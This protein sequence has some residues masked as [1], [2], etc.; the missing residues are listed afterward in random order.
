MQADRVLDV[1][2]SECWVKEFLFLARAG[3]DL[4]PSH[5]AVEQGVN[6]ADIFL[7]VRQ[8]HCAQPHGSA[9]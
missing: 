3:I 8:L 1:D 5:F 6:D 7:H 9:G 2:Q 4:G